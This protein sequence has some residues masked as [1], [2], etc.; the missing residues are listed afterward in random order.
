M[1]TSVTLYIVVMHLQI[2]SVL[3]STKII[4]V[5]NFENGLVQFKQT[6]H[7]DPVFRVSHLS[8]GMEHIYTFTD[9]EHQN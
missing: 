5:L 3:L 9:D 7:N 1:V 6:T 2:F 4:W 8:Y